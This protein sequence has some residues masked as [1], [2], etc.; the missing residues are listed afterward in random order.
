MAISTIK[1]KKSSKKNEGQKQPTIFEFP[2]PAPS[3]PADRAHGIENLRKGPT[4]LDDFTPFHELKGEEPAPQEP[5]RKPAPK[6]KWAIRPSTRLSN[7]RQVSRR[8]LLK[9][10]GYLEEDIGKLKETARKDYVNAVSRISSFLQEGGTNQPPLDPDTT[11]LR[12]VK[13]GS[14][15][16]VGTS[17]TTEYFQDPELVY[18]M[19]SYNRAMEQVREKMQE[20]V[21]A[22]QKLEEINK[23]SRNW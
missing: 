16:A 22:R 1:K 13:G 6:A 9:Q 17:Y 15:V 5:A 18:L 3:T 23:P 4:T 8:D 11:S 7:Q 21:D 20:L 2:E 19:K 10:I 14:E 12:L